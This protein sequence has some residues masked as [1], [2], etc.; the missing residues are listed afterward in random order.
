MKKKLLFRD[1][2]LLF[3]STTFILNI[4]TVAKSV[5]NKAEAIQRT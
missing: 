2:L 3:V 1:V 5:L 4:S